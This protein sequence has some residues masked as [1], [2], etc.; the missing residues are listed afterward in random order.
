MYP[1][2]PNSPARNNPHR[3]IVHDQDVEDSKDANHANDYYTQLATSVFGDTIIDATLAVATIN[4]AYMGSFAMG[5]NDP[6][7]GLMTTVVFLV[8]HS[9]NL[10][11]HHFQSREKSGLR[12]YFFFALGGL[13]CAQASFYITQLGLNS[14]FL[15]LL[16][17]SIS[18]P[19]GA[20]ESIQYEVQDAVFLT[21]AAL[22]VFVSGSCIM[23]VYNNR[24]YEPIVPQAQEYDADG[25]PYDYHEFAAPRWAVKPM[26]ELIL[27]AVNY[28]V[29]FY[30]LMAN[31]QTTTETYYRMKRLEQA[32]K[33]D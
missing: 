30:V 16:I 14:G 20:V 26:W 4:L 27:S 28:L 24:L 15:M 31:H 19:L 12:M 3:R 10:A 8:F 23:Y 11:F 1:A 5:S 6:T 32:L 18:Y 21:A 2:N 13:G 29:L 33:S 7:F 17:A 25:Y 22:G 9:M